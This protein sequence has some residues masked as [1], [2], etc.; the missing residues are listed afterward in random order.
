VF[1]VRAVATMAVVSGISAAL[2][3]Q[4][5]TASKPDGA[6]ILPRP[7]LEDLPSSGTISGLLET[8]IPEIISDRID[9][10]GLSVGRE[11]RLGAR[12]SS[13]T[14]TAFQF[15]E[16][17][18]TDAGL[19][20]KSPLFLD[21][22]ML[23]AI[24]TTTA[25]MPI[26]RSAP[27]I[28]VHLVPRR[29]SDAWRGRAEFLT[30]LSPGTAATA[31]PPPIATLRT[32]NRIAA[33]VSGPLRRDRLGVVLGFIVNDATEFDRADPTELRAQQTGV[34]AN[35][36]FT[37]SAANELFGIIAGRWAHAPLD[38][39]LGIAQPDARQQASDFMTTSHWNH[40][41]RSVSV[42]AAGAFGRDTVDANGASVPLA[43]IDSIQD[44]PIVD[45]IA[46]PRSRHH[47]S[48]SVRGSGA[49]GATNRWLRGG[50]AGVEICGAA[51]TE[52]ARLASSVAETVEGFP[53]RLWRFAAA[54]MEPR[55]HET[56]VAVYLAETLA[57]SSRL[58][59]DGAVRWEGVRAG[60]DGGG[61]LQSSDWFPR[62]A[63]RWDALPRQHLSGIL[64]LGR[65]GHRLPLELL[66]YGDPASASALV[67]RWSDRNGNERFDQGEEGP[68]V[69]RVG[70][71][72]AG[73]SAIDAELKRPYL[74][75]LFVGLELQPFARWRVRFTGLTR[76]ER[77]LIAPV[78][79]GVPIGAYTVTALPD[80]GADVIDPSD[81]QQL[82]VYNRRPEAFG[83]DRYVLTNP[84]GLSTTFDGLEL[85]V[86]HRGDRLL[87]MAG[88]TAGRVSG[89]AAARGFRVF[90]NDGA[91]P[92]DAFLDPNASTFVRGSFFS[93]RSYTIKTAGTY[94]L[95]H[96]VRIGV[97]A[98]Y[99]DG[100]PFSR[101]V[102][103][104]NV[105]QGAEAIR[106]YRNG[107]TRFSYTMT[108][109]TRAQVGFHV[110][111][112]RLA[113]VWDVFNLF[114]MSNEVEE[115]VVTGPAFRTPT[116]LQPPRTMHLGLRLGF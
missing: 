100:E 56:T 63:L 18:V 71:A 27:G 98:R 102:V 114:N 54:D 8:T 3:A 25:M 37:P 26:E 23:E 14:Q 68:L 113:L 12:G 103:V 65:Y 116:A 73:T 13:W 89:P 61:T 52:T 38:G 70:D 41:A 82:P 69:A 59:I 80:P 90:E 35:V 60:A 96:D 51:D 115:S 9:A 57:V 77:R 109:D 95:P 1:L 110:A 53:A 10:G 29:P 86:W 74:D 44:M 92:T 49:A 87:V 88:A 19:F 20:G 21:P 15:D 76:Q 66:A 47:W 106:A 105:N 6:V 67:F 48:A 33:S 36:R 32:W 94:L 55:H 17:D 50:R 39:R 2:C 11:S 104:Q 16:S 81:D 72:P 5:P 62:V 78:N 43:Y 97:V 28:S 31:L 42:T 64:G 107:R 101:L 108:I 22:E 58:T 40:R 7:A 34:F 46:T 30:T 112:Q 99:Q 93:D 75:E 4:S 84:Q 83:T 24:E 45:A 111:R 79:I 91:L 85:S